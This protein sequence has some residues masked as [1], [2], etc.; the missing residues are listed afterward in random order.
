MRLATFI[1]VG[2]SAPTAA[3]AAAYGWVDL[4]AFLRTRGLSASPNSSLASLLPELM[5]R[6]AELTA[7]LESPEPLWEVE[8]LRA[9]GTFLQ[10]QRW[11]P[12]IPQPPSFRDFYAFEQHVKTCRAKRGLEM[13]PA[14]YQIP[15]F[16]FSNPG[17]LVG[18]D[19]EVY[20][21]FGSEELDYELE[22][23]AVIGRTC[24]DTP[25]DRAWSCVAGFTVINDLSARDLQRAEV[26]VG[27]GPA[28]G[29]D[30]AT[31]VGPVLVTID[32][33]AD[34]IAADRIELSMRASVNGRELSSGNSESLHHTFPQLIAQASRDATLHPGDLIGSG[35]VGTGCVLELGP[36]RTGGWLKP[37]DLVE[38]EIERIGRLATRIVERPSSNGSEQAFGS[39][40]KPAR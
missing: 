25:A 8:Y 27:L 11:L 5:P 38:L 18:H 19:A 6:L 31:A 33:F 22:L 32:E 28:K 35:T 13:P 4:V 40:A 7:D 26:T 37:G 29:K 12:P 39:P 23:G 20:A 1:P 16:Y 9:G 24:R 3:A 17:S 2:A 21:P 15:V 10:P 14:W 34:C 30:F 36:E